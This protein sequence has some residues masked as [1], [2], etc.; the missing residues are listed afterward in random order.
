MGESEK[1][2]LEAYLQRGSFPG[3]AEWL[4]DKNTLSLWQSIPIM[5]ILHS[6]LPNL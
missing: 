5:E 2:M 4:T 1:K 3:L 6:G